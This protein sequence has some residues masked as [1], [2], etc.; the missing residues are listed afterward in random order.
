MEIYAEINKKM[1]K[2]I[3]EDGTDLI[4]P[5]SVKMNRK[6]GSRACYF[7]CDKDIKNDLIGFLDNCSFFNTDLDQTIL[8]LKINTLVPNLII[9]ENIKQMS[10]KKYGIQ[11]FMKIKKFPKQKFLKKK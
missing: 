8:S 6:Q 2:K 9:R 1:L 4:L 10:K 5:S 11:G 7:E 3:E